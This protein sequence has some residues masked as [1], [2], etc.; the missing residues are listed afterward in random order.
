MPPLGDN[1]MNDNYADNLARLV[2]I[3]DPHRYSLTIDT[4]RRTVWLSFAGLDHEKVLRDVRSAFPDAVL[5]SWGDTD[6]VPHITF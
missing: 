1:P 6:L 3:L 4:A 2:T 5:F